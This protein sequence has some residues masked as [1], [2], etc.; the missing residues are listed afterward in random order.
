MVKKPL[1]DNCK[2]NVLLSTSYRQKLRQK[3]A[4]S[5]AVDAILQKKTD[6]FESMMNSWRRHIIE[7]WCHCLAI[8]SGARMLFKACHCV[9]QV[10]LT[11]S[12]PPTTVWLKDENLHQRGKQLILQM[13]NG[14]TPVS[15]HGTRVLLHMVLRSSHSTKWPRL[16]SWSVIARPFNASGHNEALTTAVSFLAVTL[17]MCMFADCTGTRG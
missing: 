13:C 6:E 12:K 10:T 17:Y 7:E 3:Q 5:K 1:T 14:A 16:N 2:P 11:G 9:S 15:V 4:L 8:L